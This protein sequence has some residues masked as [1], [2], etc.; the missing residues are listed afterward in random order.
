MQSQYC[1]LGEWYPAMPVTLR[2]NLLAVFLF[3][4]FDRFFPDFFV[5][6]AG[7]NLLDMSAGLEKG[8]RL[9]RDRCTG[10]LV[11]SRFAL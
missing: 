11:G 3:A 8:V 5:S 6:H 10:E 7:S 9:F 1:A 4:D 2:L